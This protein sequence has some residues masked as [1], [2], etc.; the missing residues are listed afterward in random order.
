MAVDAGFDMVPSLS[1]GMVDKHNWESFLKVIRERNE[2]DPLVEV[3]P[4]YILFKAGEHP[5][6]PLECHKFHVSVRRFRAA[7][8]GQLR[9]IF[10]LPQLWRR[11]CSVLAPSPGMMLRTRL[12]IIAGGRWMHRG[13]PMNG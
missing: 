1:K 12:A 2:N 4:N 6:L 11:L 3:M 10:L 9:T 13:S 5:K 7:M 8:P